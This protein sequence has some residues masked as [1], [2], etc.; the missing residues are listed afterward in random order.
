HI[1]LKT[2]P[3]RGHGLSLLDRLFYIEPVVYWLTFPFMLLLLLAPIVFWYTGAAVFRASAEQMVLLL[4]PRLLAGYIIGY[5]LSEGKVLPVVT[6]VH[7]ALPVFHLTG[8]V[9][10]SLVAPFGRP[11][12]VTAKGV[13][14]DGVLVQWRIAWPFLALAVALLGGMVL[15]LTGWREIVAIGDLTPLDV[16]W[17]VYSLLVFTLCFLACI[18]L[19]R[20]SGGST[21]A[22]ARIDVIGT[23]RSLC[24]RL[25]A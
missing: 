7:K 1:F 23:V 17:S 21:Q 24:K 18:E 19:P 10:K 25:F 12:Q 2:G 8:A 20:A 11:F 6:T 3:I 5:W 15:N 16:A 22:V 4:L 9:L 13:T 14:R